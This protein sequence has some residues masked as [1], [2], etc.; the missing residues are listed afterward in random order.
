MPTTTAVPLLPVDG[1]HLLHRARFGF[2]KRDRAPD[3][4][5]V[6]GARTRTSGVTT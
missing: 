3:S 4:S 1:H 2:P 5:D 6:T